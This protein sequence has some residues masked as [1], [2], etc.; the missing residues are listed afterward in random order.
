[1]EN[2][3][4]QKTSKKG[5]PN[6]QGFDYFY[7]FNRHKNAHHYYPENIWENENFIAVEGNVTQDKIG[8]YSQDLFT[9]KALSFLENQSAEKPFFL[10][11]AYTIPHFELTIPEEQKKQYKDL[12]WPLRK[13]KSSA[14]SS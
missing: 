14:L 7:G 4:W 9:E 12:N 13:M 3:D 2:G 1:M 11:L 10:Y 8:Q 6:L 5:T